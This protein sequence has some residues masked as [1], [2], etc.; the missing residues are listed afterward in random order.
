MVGRSAAVRVLA[1][2][3]DG[4]EA[5]A[6]AALEDDHQR[7]LAGAALRR[8]R[9]P[10]ERPR[11]QRRTRPG[12]GPTTSGRSGGWSCAISSGTRRAQSRSA[13]RPRA[14]ADRSRS[15][16]RV[17]TGATPRS[18]RARP[19]QVERRSSGARA[20]RSSRPRRR[21]CPCSRSAAAAGRAACPCRAMR[22]A[23]VARVATSAP[24]ARTALT[25]NSSGVLTF[26]ARAA[27]AGELRRGDDRRHDRADVAVRPAEG[28]G[29]A[30]HERRRRL[31]GHEAPRQLVRDE[32]RGGRVR[33]QHVQDR[34]PS[35]LPP[36]LMRVP[37]TVLS[38]RSCM[39]AS[40]A[41]SG[42]P[43]RRPRMVQ[44]VKQRATSVTSFC[45]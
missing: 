33:R 15:D 37:R 24:E 41:N 20:G 32:A 10:H 1:V 45:V 42:S 7:L 21:R 40:N 29:R 11:R 14:S 31:V 36:P 3:D 39:R 13:S 16:A 44:P 30:V 35:S 23:S 43:S 22:R 12:P 5:V 2:G 27:G 18:T 28:V 17:P 6:G 8:V 25:T 34:S 26:A 9:R 4:V 19:A 38:P